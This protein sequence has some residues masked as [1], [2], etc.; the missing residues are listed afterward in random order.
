MWH[1]W[2]RDERLVVAERVDV[3]EAV[4]SAPPFSEIEVFVDMEVSFRAVMSRSVDLH[5]L[6]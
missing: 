2:V 1:V 5:F 3:V 6:W 4:R